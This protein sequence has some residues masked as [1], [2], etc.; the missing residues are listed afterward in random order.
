MLPFY[1]EPGSKITGKQIALPLLFGLA[2][3]G[4]VYWFI[5]KKEVVSQSKTYENDQVASSSLSDWVDEQPQLDDEPAESGDQEKEFAVLPP[6][7]PPSMEK[8][9]KRGC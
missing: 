6:P 3:L 5:L 7:P 8:M 9:K 2:L 1:Y 4:A